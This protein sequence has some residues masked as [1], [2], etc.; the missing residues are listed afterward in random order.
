MTTLLLFGAGVAASLLVVGTVRG[1]LRLVRRLKDR[2]VTRQ[3]REA[4][5]RIL[6][7]AFQAQQHINWT[8]FQARQ[9]LRAEAM[10]L[11]GTER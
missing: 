5:L 2:R 4:Q 1:V 8:L 10:R 9:I 11:R 3:R 7:D 6:W